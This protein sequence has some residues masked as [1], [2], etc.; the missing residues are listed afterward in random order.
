MEVIHGNIFTTKCQTI[1][2]TVNCY[3]VMG[4][5]IALEC[6]YRYPEMNERYVELCK[7]QLLQVGNLFLYKGDKKW[8]LNFPTKNHWKFPSKK[9]YL[10]KGLQKFVDTYEKK[11]ITSIAFPLL[12]ASHGGLSPEDSFHIMEEYLKNVSI[13]VEIYKYN[14][15]IPDD[16]FPKFQKFLQNTDLTKLK[17]ETGLSKKQLTILLDAIETNSIYNMMGLLSIKGVGDKVIQKCYAFA[18]QIENQAIQGK[19]F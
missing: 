10:L 2:N 9:Q 13:P 3:G 15:E 16:L 17:L 14:P 11:G 4:A 7:N 8:I 6:K 5:G 12:G 1:V 18:M 19:L